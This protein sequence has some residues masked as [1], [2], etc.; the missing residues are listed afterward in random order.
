MR[1]RGDFHLDCVQADVTGCL[2]WQLYEEIRKFIF[3]FPRKVPPAQSPLLLSCHILTPHHSPAGRDS[4]HFIAGSSAR[5]APSSP[6]QYYLIIT[7]IL[8]KQGHPPHHPR[9]PPPRKCPRPGDGEDL[10]GENLILIWARGR[11][12]L[13]MEMATKRSM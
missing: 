11:L 7:A 13:Q 10:H 12:Q 1:V 4:H 6:W 5:V 3:N 2:E 8:S 9:P